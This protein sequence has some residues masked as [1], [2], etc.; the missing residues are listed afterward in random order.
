MNLISLFLGGILT[1]NIVL[2]KFLGLCPFIGASNNK[3]NALKMGLSVTI[4]LFISS[5]ITYPVYH[6]ILVKLD[7]EYLMTLL[8]ILIIAFV[9]QILEMIFKK[10][11]PHIHQA[12][13]IYLP[14]ITT[15][16]AI[17]GLLL[18]NINNE[19]NFIEAVIN[20][21]GSGLGF[22]LV[23]YIFGSMREKLE[24]SD[25]PKNFRG[26]P[27]ALITAGIMAMIFSRY[28]GG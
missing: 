20:S 15:N 12:L 7:A 13:D 17:L 4:V 26:V 2:T 8:F 9:V 27:I 5:I 11:F 19:Y 22:T 21:I 18:L 24:I 23:I 28:I 6:F 3:N 14:L 1:N 25:V 10:Y 16:C